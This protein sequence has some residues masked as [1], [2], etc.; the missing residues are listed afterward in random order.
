M[1]FVF[2]SILDFLFFIGLKLN[3]FDLYKIDEFFNIYFFDNQNL[4]VLIP[5]T[6]ILGYFLLFSKFAKLCIKIY[7]GI[8]IL[9]TST[10]YEPIGKSLGERVFLIENQRFKL[11]KI[12]FSGDK[13]YEGRK[14]IYI[15]RRDL[16]KTIKLLKSEVKN[17]T[18]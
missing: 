12:T 9:F 11:G 2:V 6:L 10:F 14:F 17:I 3:Y 7:I 5:S 18:I 16:N 8:I 4:Y 15:Y 13:L 1:G